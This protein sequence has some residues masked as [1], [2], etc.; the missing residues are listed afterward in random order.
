MVVR[1]APWLE[2][3][4]GDDEPMQ[5]RGRIQDENAFRRY[6]ES[7]QH[8]KDPAGWL[9]PRFVRR[10]KDD[11]D[12]RAHVGEEPG[13][14]QRLHQEVSEVVEQPTEIDDLLDYLMFVLVVRDGC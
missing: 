6:T 4:F 13:A 12:G 3:R 8:P 5:S 10:V 14:R 2:E 1:D 11:A 7:L 9:S